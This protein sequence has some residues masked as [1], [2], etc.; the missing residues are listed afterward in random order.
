MQHF[1]IE[2]R[3]DSTARVLQS[4][5]G[6]QKLYKH[7]FVILLIELVY[8]GVAGMEARID[9]Y[10]QQLH[11]MMQALD[12][13][14][15]ASLV[16][17]LLDVHERGGTIYTF[18]NGGSGATAS[19]FCGDLLKDVSHGL[20]K[21]FKAVCLNDNSPA[22]LA[23][24]NDISYTD[25]FVEQLRNFLHQDDLVIGISGSGNSENVIRAISYAK[26]KGV[27]TIGLC[28]FDGGRLKQIA[29]ACVHIPIKNM[30]ISEDL[31]LC[32]LHCT[33]MTLM[34][35]LKHQYTRS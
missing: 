5:A 3:A 21:R 4:A 11:K 10:L 33:K 22:L 31:H 27:S 29:G 16:Q 15:I 19:H 7:R 13:A 24:A 34:D 23:I 2:N 1:N 35:Q 9:A 12:K 26:S 25:I 32:V 17:A 18:G 14:Q 20:E 28:G 6:G 8:S 30:E